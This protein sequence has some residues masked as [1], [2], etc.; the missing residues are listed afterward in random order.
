L[1]RGGSDAVILSGSED[2]AMSCGVHPTPFFAVPTV[3]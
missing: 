3:H 1:H 2:D